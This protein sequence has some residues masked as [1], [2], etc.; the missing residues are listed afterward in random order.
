AGKGIIIAGRRQPAVVHALVF[1]VNA[2]LGNLG[3]TIE[4]RTPTDRPARGSLQDLISSID[5]NEVETLLI[6]GGNPAY[7]AP[8][9]LEFADRL[10]RIPTT[11]RMGLHADETSRLAT[12]HVPMAHDLESWGDARAGDGS[13]LAIQPMIEPLFGGRSMLEELARLSSYQPSSA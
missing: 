7:T 3:K 1:A 13:L 8:A 5:K 10:K 11:I 12:W 9:D 6:L 2:L 4:L